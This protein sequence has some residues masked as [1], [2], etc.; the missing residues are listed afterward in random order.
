MTLSEDEQGRLDE[1]ESCT[2]SADPV[3]AA[4]LDLPAA[5]RRRRQR[6]LLSQCGF[7]IGPLI[8]IIGAGRRLRDDLRRNV[9]GVL[10]VHHHR[11][12]ERDRPARPV[13]TMT[14]LPGGIGT[15][16]RSSLELGAQTR[17]AP[18]RP[19]LRVPVDG[20]E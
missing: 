8:L 19:S 1:I 11:V 20:R 9:R 3:F 2:R 15:S 14:A 4:S 16:W 10:R 17:C 18:Q 5:Q 12:G 7:W 6:V 13:P